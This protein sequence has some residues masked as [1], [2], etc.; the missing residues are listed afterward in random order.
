MEHPGELICLLRQQHAERTRQLR[1]FQRDL[2]SH[3][4]VMTRLLVRIEENTR[5]PNTPPR[6]VGSQ[7]LTVGKPTL[8]S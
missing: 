4:R 1:L 7:V 2:D 8:E 3:L 5:P 6:E